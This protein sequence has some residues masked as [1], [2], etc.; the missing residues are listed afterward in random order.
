MN[1][2]SLGPFIKTTNDAMELSQ[3]LDSIS[4]SLFKTD[5]SALEAV[6]KAVPYDLGVA[7]NKLANEHNVGMDD[8]AGV[9]QFFVKVQESLTTMPVVKLTIAVKPKAELIKL[10]HGWFYRTY[11]KVVLLDFTVNPDIMGGSIISVGGKYY[12]GSIAKRII[13]GPKVQEQEAGSPQL[14]LAPSP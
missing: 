2:Q 7:L 13:S 1:I 6:M 4:E 14:P 10:I 5:A 9:Q 11:H 12:D 3:V 8:K